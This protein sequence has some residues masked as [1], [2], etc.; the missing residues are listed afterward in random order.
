[1]VEKSDTFVLRTHH[2]WY[3]GPLDPNM[4]FNGHYGNF[5]FFV[6]DWQN[7]P[8][9]TNLNKLSLY[10]ISIFC[11]YLGISKSLPNL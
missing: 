11:P 2:G 7:S 8:E 10:K 9:N 3:F 1:M 5:T 4:Q 6:L